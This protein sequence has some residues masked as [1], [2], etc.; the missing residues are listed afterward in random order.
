MDVRWMAH[1]NSSNVLR[2]RRSWTGDEICAATIV[3]DATGQ[4]AIDRLTVEQDAGRYRGSLDDEPAQFEL[5]LTTVVS[6]IRDLRG[7]PSP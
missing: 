5:V 3:E 4:A 7:S 1:L 6:L 2:L